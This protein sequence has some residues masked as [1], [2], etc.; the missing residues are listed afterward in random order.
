M[1]RSEISKILTDFGKG[2]NMNTVSPRINEESVRF[3]TEHFGKKNRGAAVI[4]D[5]F[6]RLYARTMVAL[7]GRFDSEAL[8]DLI[9][10]MAA[11]RRYS[12]GS[13]VMNTFLWGIGFYSVFTAC[14]T[15]ELSC[16]EIWAGAFYSQTGKDLATYVAE[17][18][19]KE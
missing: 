6:P 8:N 14:T 5:S 4:L 7:R 2:K 1:V 13:G 15:F 17:L 12:N 18:A 10:G 9:E 3:Y 16:L 19:K 11:Y